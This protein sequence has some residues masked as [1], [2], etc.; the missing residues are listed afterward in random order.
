[1][2]KQ[3]LQKLRVADMHCL[4]KQV[5]ELNSTM[6]LMKVFGWS[7]QPLLERP[8]IYDYHYIED[9]NER[10]IRDAE[11]LGSVMRNARP[12]VALEIGTSQGKGTVL[13]ALNAPEAKIYTVNIPP[14]EIASGAGGVFTTD[15]LKVDEIGS[16]YRDRGLSNVVQILANTASWE[17]DI[18]KIGVAFIDGCHDTDFVVRDTIKVLA[19]MQPGGFIMWHDF[20]P[21]LAKKFAWVGAVCEGVERLC[22]KGLIRGRILH[23]R[24]SWIGVYR[25]PEG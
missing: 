21:G 16:A 25:V 13:M 20:N 7:H 4:D 14:E 1:M 10:R 12:A 24:D 22:C 19:H 8:D 11:V 15:T 23:V 6:E 9:A 3:L 2:L 5:I 17:P 18:G